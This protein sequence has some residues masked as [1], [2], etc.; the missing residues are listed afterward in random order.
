[1]A[2]PGEGLTPTELLPSS[3]GLV[4]AGGSKCVR[5]PQRSQA[6]GA[7]FTLSPFCPSHLCTLQ[8]S[9]QAGDHPP[10]LSQAQRDQDSEPQALGSP[11][12]GEGGSGPP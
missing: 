6:Q 7:V 8:A 11:A 12:P 9:E 3:L 10:W 2:S 1:M 4:L 5:G